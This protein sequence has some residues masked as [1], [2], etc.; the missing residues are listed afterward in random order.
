MNDRQLPVLDRHP[1]HGIHAPT[2]AT[3][4]R[5]PGSW[6]ECRSLRTVRRTWSASLLAGLRRYVGGSL[7]G[8]PS[9]THLN[10][11]LRSHEDVV[12]AGRLGLTKGELCKLRI[13][14]PL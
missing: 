9:C 14:P 1:R 2:M 5:A 10:D 4:R 11:L 13:G 6:V 7:A 3:P 8:V 12:G